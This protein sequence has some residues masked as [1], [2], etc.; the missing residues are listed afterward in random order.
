M[1]NTTSTPITTNIPRK[2][3]TNSVALITGASQRI[4]KAITKNLHDTGYCVIIHFYKN[5]QA[6]QDLATRLNQQR[7]NS[8]IALQANLK[9]TEEVTTLAEKAQAHWGRLDLLINNASTFEA[10]K[11]TEALKT[12]Q[13]QDIIDTN[14]R[15]AWLLSNL[16]KTSLTK[17]HGSII[18]L[19]DIYAERPLKS[20]SIY[21][22][23]KAGIAMLCKS[24]ALEFAPYIRVN[25]I[26][27]GAILW[28]SNQEESSETQLT[29]QQVIL[30]KIPLKKL[31][32][33]KAITETVQF[34]IRCDYISGQVIN[35]DGGRSINI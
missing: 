16:L 11:A 13:W 27:P 26:A 33:T 15:A 32:S 28:P 25:G 10:D 23:S 24:L 5:E 3:K 14:L 8:A 7:E 31:G 35:V 4:G 30:N 1:P 6:A 12:V 22:T 19:V 29:H 17:H 21:S 2:A 20:H 18:N 9:Q 34:L